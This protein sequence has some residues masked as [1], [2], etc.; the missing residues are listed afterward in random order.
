[1][2]TQVMKLEQLPVIKHQLIQMGEKVT[3]RLNDL[4]IESQIATDDSI[5]ALKSLRSDL[6]KEAKEFE[7]QRKFI[8]NGIMNPYTEFE[9]VYKEHIIDKYKD[10]VELLKIKINDFELS[11]KKG[12]QDNLKKYFKEIKEFENLG[13]LKWEQLKMD[14]NLSTSEKKYK[15][16]ILE[17]T[18]QI[19]D[20]LE[21]INTDQYAAEIL[22]E[23][24][25]SLNASNSIKMIRN[26]KQKEKEEKERILFERTGRRTRS[27]IS[28]NFVYSDLTRTYNWINDEQVMISLSDVESLDDSYWIVRFEDLKAKSTLKEE[29]KFV[30]APIAQAP[31]AQAPAEKLDE[32]KKEEKKEE[33]FEAT[34]SVKGTYAELKTLG[35]FLK[36]N[37]YEY[38]NL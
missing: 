29:P 6:N 30:K 20:D 32:Q 13:W 5:K 36:S 11:V 4:N 26:R 21:L 33:V 16:Q 1:M 7:E 23:Y 34:F 12:K 3:R 15:E 19:L 2:N 31:A 28:L 18:N 38:K 37:N 35:E 9:G 24:K 10:A 22:V 17:F 8:K 14:V 25:A 27:L